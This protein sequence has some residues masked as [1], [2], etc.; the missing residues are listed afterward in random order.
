MTPSFYPIETWE[1]R[2]L[3]HLVNYEITTI[4]ITRIKSIINNANIR[5]G[6]NTFINII[7]RKYKV[8]QLDKP[9]I[10]TFIDNK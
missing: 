1:M 2:I 6:I 7:A 5:N 10:F 8:N 3:Y 9:K 4:K